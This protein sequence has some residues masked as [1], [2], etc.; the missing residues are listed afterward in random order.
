M[1]TSVFSKSKPVNYIL[2]TSLLVLCFFL[3]QLARPEWMESG[4]GI[5]EKTVILLVLVA[6]LFMVN[7]ITK[8][9][10]LSK[11]NSFAF[12]LFFIFLI[13]FPKILNDTNIVLSNF[14]ILLS[15]RRM[16]SLQSLVTPKEKIFD[17]SLWIFIAALFHF[18]SILFII[19]VFISI[20][21]HVAGDYRNWIIPFIAFFAVFTIY[22]LAG[23]VFDKTLIT[24]LF[25]KA[26]F[27]FDLNYFKNSFHNIALGLYV[28]LAALFL[29]GQI[30]SLPNKPLNLH[31]S[32]KKF[33]FFF[34]IG[35]VIFLISPNK[36]NSLLAFTFAPLCVMGANFIEL[37]HKYWMKETVIGIVLL[38]TIF[39]FISQ[40]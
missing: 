32:Y 23:L 24:G 19:L 33:I 20:I 34:I 17:A 38:L 35:V 6:S 10:G 16:V 18:W 14:F 39:T 28:V 31:A 30:F 11:D 13:L 2:I 27:D 25:H 15:L 7:F 12:F 36:S 1:I 3:Y 4:R 40:L 21:F 37:L 9:N 8:K 5:A 26:V 22:I 29:L